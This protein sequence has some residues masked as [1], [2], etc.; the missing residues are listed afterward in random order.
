MS[1]EGRERIKGGNGE[2]NNRKA[3]VKRKNIRIKT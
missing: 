1:I 3:Q 2:G